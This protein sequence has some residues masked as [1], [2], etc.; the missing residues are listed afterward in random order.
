[1]ALGQILGV[2]VVGEAPELQDGVAAQVVAEIVLGRLGIGA[3]L[4]R[5]Q[6]DD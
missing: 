4:R 2:A 5:V 3:A 6:S 1:M